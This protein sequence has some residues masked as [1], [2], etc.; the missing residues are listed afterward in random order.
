MTRRRRREGTGLFAGVS[1]ILWWL[2]PLALLAACGRIVV[3]LLVQTTLDGFEAG[4]AARS[5]PT[6]LVVGTSALVV[7]VL[8]SAVMNRGLVRFVEH[9]IAELRT[10]M[11]SHLLRLPAQEVERHPSGAFVS[12]LVSDL[13]TVSQYIAGGG[14]HLVLNLGQMLLAAAV[15]T[16]YS[17]PLA[18]LVVLLSVPILLLMGAVRSRIRQRHVVVR[19]RIGAL[20]ATVGDL[21]LGFEVLR[22]FGLRADA[23]RRAREAIG[24]LR[25]ALQRT[26]PPLH[27]NTSV[28]EASGNIITVVVLFGGVV[29]GTLIAPGTLSAGELVAYLFLINFFVR[30]MQFTV[31]N[32]GE[33][34]SAVA[35]LRRAAAVLSAPAEYEEPDAGSPLPETGFEIV[36]EDLAF[37]YTADQRA[38]AGIDVEIRPREF[39]AVVGE[40]GSGKTTFGK[41]LSRQLRADEGR[42]VFGGVDLEEV[43]AHALARRI[44]VVPQEPFLFDRTIRENLVLARADVSAEEIEGL[45]AALGLDRWLAGLPDGIETRVGRA[46]SALSGGQRQLVA[47]ARTALLDPSLLILDEATSNLDPRLERQVQQALRALARERTTIA[48]AH[49]LQTAVAADRVLV[50]SH[51]RLVEDD[52]PE[53]LLRRRSHFAR[54]HADWVGR[55]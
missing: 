51:G 53:E 46:G 6:V 50:F 37:G 15:M 29:L 40:T 25:Q 9:R 42:I 31:A 48:I 45:L 18:A 16:W 4:A 21:V 5:A 1:G 44:A 38:L 26:Q 17:P 20:H 11:F 7:A 22:V 10:R 23:E 13:D 3:P 54:L 32:L 55:G 27:L 52:A 39:V 34:Q 30:P 24:G 19:E 12:R 35:G 14:V 8:A 49:R 33:A 36:V 47:L 41:L 28:G 2:I 43:S